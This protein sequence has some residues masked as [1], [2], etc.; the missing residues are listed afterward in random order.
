MNTK[1]GNGF[2]ARVSLAQLEKVYTQEKQAK[3]KI[4]LQ[5]AIL[6]KKGENLPFMAGVTGLP[7]TTISG[8]LAR[9]EQRGIAAKD[10]VRQQGQPRKITEKQMKQ[11]KQML[12]KT[13]KEQRLPFVIW[14]TKLVQYIIKKKFGVSY[15]LMQVHRILKRLGLSLQKPRPEHLKANKAL[16]QRF[17]KNFGEELRSLILSDMRSSFWTK[18]P[19]SLSPT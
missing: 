14:T 9:F 10:A 19:T 6:R 16:Q 18:A 15:V 12:N 13:P 8:I 11:L 1:R 2:L 7:M 3:A 17:K 5:C 4:R